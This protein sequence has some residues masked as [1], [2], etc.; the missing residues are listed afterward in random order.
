MYLSGSDSEV[1][2]YDK[3]DVTIE[4]DGATTIPQ[5]K[6]DYAVKLKAMLD[7]FDKCLLININN[8]TSDQIHCMRKDMR[9]RVTFLFGKNTLI[10]KVIRDYVKETRQSSLMNLMEVVRGNIGFAFTKDEVAPLRKEIEGRKRQAPAK[11]GVVSPVDVIIPAG[12][13]GMEPT[14]TAMFQ[15]MDIPTRINRGQID[16]EEP[17]QC[18]WKGQKVGA[19]EAAML[20]KLGIKPFY[21]GIKVEKIFENGQ[22]IDASVL[23]I[24]PEEIAGSFSLGVQKVAALCYEIDYPTICN[25]PHTLIHAYKDALALCLDFETYKWEG[26]EHIREVLKNPGAFSGPA[27]GGGGGGDATGG[28]AAAEQEPEPEEESSSAAAPGGGMF[29]DD[30]DSDDSSS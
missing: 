15:A 29:G 18:V 12:P 10:R 1:I 17:V 3:I 25:V 8:V 21:Y 20:I 4:G 16:I 2:D 22:I 19:S 30:S 11:A 14:Q 7:E 23:D 5:R 6:L 24:T 28:A 27:T 9:G 26:L 13:T